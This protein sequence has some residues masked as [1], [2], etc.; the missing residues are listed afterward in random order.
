MAAAS[1]PILMYNHCLDELKGWPDEAALDFDAHLSPNTKVDPLYGGR[2]V[3]VNSA[4]EFEPGISGTQMA[5]FLLQGSHELDVNNYGGNE[6]TA[7]APTG[8]MSG[9]VDRKSVV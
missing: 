3:H 8:K 9:L 2:V 5:I 7:I 1:G 6:W 4:G